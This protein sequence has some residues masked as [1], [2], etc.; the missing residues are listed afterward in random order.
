MGKTLTS[1]NN[2]KTDAESGKW[3]EVI[4]RSAAC[5]F[6]EQLQQ[7]VGGTRGAQIAGSQV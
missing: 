4:T 7:E 3:E 5:C 1:D 2:Y 6:V